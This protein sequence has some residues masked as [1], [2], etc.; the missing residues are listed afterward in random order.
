MQYHLRTGN[1]VR[2]PAAQGESAAGPHPV[3]GAH[4]V[5]DCAVARIVRVGGQR[6]VF[7]EV[8]RPTV[9]GDAPP[10]PYGRRRFASRPPDA[11]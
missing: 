1:P 2:G 10:L 8:V 11:G 4:S 7:G 5:A 3:R 6:I 9:F